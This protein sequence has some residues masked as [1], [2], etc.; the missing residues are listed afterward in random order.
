MNGIWDQARLQR[1]ITDQIEENLTLDYKA[2]DAL[3]KTD[4]KRK[5]VTKDVSAFANSAGGII[6]YGMREYDEAARKHLPEKLDPIDRNQFSKEWL[7]QVIGNIRP[8]IEAM[9][10][11]PVSLNGISTHVAYIVEIPKSIT[12]HQATDYRYYRRFNFESVPMEDYEIQDIRNRRH[13]FLPLVKFDVE[14]R[15]GVAITLV[16]SN[17]G[18]S[19]AQDVKFNFLTPLVWKD[20][21]EM[22]PLLK[23]GT[24]Y[25]SPGEIHKFH[26]ESFLSTV[27]NEIPSNIDVEV[28]YIH[29][30][31]GQR[32]SDVF[33]V[34]FKNY[35]NS[36]VNE[37]ELYQLGKTIEKALGKLADK[38]QDTNR[39]LDALSE[40]ANS[41]GLQIS[42]PTLRNLR[43]I[44]DRSTQL[45]K[46]DPRGRS[47]RFFM[48]VLG[49]D[50]TRASRLSSYYHN[51]ED[52]RL[53][54]LE[55]ISEELVAR[56]KEIFI[57]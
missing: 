40:I 7:E 2:S 21:R 3:A 25:L 19:I 55:D 48:E 28:S 13:T 53:K 52:K 16:V 50:A 44:L 10:I 9:L 33:R 17:I 6:I 30:E 12:A 56:I 5:E 46:L 54:D 20:N 36:L 39:H 41:T 57:E 24:K 1:Y 11:H 45:E 35:Q 29:P 31:I 34:D 4:G 38:I 49:I 26:Y 27:N 51:V 23:D 8:R 18:N 37:P 42:V 14:V 43:Y 15:H 47:F 32:I 22:P